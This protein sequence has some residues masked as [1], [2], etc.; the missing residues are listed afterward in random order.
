MQRTTLADIPTIEAADEIQG[1]VLDDWDANMRAIGRMLVGRN[2]AG[3]WRDV[4]RVFVDQQD[5]GYRPG[6][7]A[8]FLEEV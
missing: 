2:E 8:A 5:L 6:D 1:Q 7:E 4:Y 3:I